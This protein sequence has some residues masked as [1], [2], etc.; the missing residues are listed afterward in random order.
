[1]KKALATLSIAT[2]FSLGSCGT[3]STNTPV[4]DDLDFDVVALTAKGDTLFH[5]VVDHMR[6]SG[7][8]ADTPGLS[9][10]DDINY[11]TDRGAWLTEKETGNPY[12][13]SPGT[14][15]VARPIPA[16]K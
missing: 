8:S 13:T 5:I 12:Y 11:I 4:E 6:L 1:M 7:F 15:L 16:V 3:E 2:A 14:T 10:K 9:K